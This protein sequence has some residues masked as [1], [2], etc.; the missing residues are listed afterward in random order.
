YCALAIECITLLCAH[1]HTPDDQWSLSTK[2]V[3]LQSAILEITNEMAS[4]IDYAWNHLLDW[5]DKGVVSLEALQSY[6]DSPLQSL[7][8]FID[9]MIQQTCHPGVFQGLAYMGFK[10]FHGMKFQGI[11]ASNGLMVHLAGP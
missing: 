8:G 4:Y 11:V 3:W 1:L 9:C 6:V 5:D 10:K 2:Y 7:F